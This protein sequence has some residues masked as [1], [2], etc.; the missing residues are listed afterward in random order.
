MNKQ[1]QKEVKAVDAFIASLGDQGKKFLDSLH[2][3]GVTT[4][5]M[6]PGVQFD[7]YYNTATNTMHLDEGLPLATMFN[8]RV[9]EGVHAIHTR[10]YQDMQAAITNLDLSAADFLK[11]RRAMEINAH[12]V[13]AYF[14]ILAAHKTGDASFLNAVSNN[15]TMISF[16]AEMEELA[17]SQYTAEESANI[18][19]RKLMN[20]PVEKTDMVPE[21][22]EYGIRKL[23]D[24]FDF[25]VASSL[26]GRKPKEA[27]STIS[28]SDLQGILNAAL[29]L[30]QN[31]SDEIMERYIDGLE[32]V[33]PFSKAMLMISGHE[34]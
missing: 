32:D 24:T 4:E 16:A 31:S 2:D 10:P 12:Y 9:H 29:P 23:G 11:I 26:C 30:P 5:D 27:H 6:E 7:A 3:T 15:F 13:Q 14:C 34:L 1:L 8:Y 20:L 25:T 21:L 22:E 28:R 17:T 19:A 18:M 33:H